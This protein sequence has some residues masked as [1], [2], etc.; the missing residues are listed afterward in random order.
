MVVYLLSRLSNLPNTAPLLCN[1]I[2]EQLRPTQLSELTNPYPIKQQHRA[3][4]CTFPLWY[5]GLLKPQLLYILLLLLF[6]KTKEK[7]I[8]VIQWEKSNKHSFA[9]MQKGAVSGYTKS[10]GL[11]WWLSGRE[12]TCLCKR[13]RFHPWVE[14]PTPVFLPGEPHG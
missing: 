3:V 11:L 12:V 10:F 4:K 14:Q 7:A 8:I 2:I 9:L 1:H 5:G 6:L 13:C